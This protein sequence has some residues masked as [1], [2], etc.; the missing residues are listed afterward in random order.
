MGPFVKYWN[1]KKTLAL[2]LEQSQYLMAALVNILVLTMFILKRKAIVLTYNGIQSTFTRLSEEKGFDPNI[3]Y[4]KNIKAIQFIIG[5]TVFISFSIAF[6]PLLAAV[7]DLGELP[8]D[9][10]SHWPI[11]WPNVSR[12]YVFK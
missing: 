1:E 6:G 4:R 9:E 5:P 8:L 11:F 7:N 2:I 10:R 3:V 12:Q